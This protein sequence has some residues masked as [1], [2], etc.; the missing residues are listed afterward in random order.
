MLRR[1]LSYV[2]VDEKS[3]EKLAE[4]VET[5][6]AGSDFRHKSGIGEYGKSC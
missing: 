6:M 5:M 4:I 2:K 3:N 1:R